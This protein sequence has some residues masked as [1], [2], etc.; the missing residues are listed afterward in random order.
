MTLTVTMT[1][2]VW[3]IGRPDDIYDPTSVLQIP[4]G[5]DGDAA[6]GPRLHDDSNVNENNMSS[7]SGSDFDESGDPLGYH[8]CSDCI[9]C[10][11]CESC[12]YVLR[13]R[14]TIYSP[15]PSLGHSC[16]LYRFG[17][18]QCTA[19]WVTGICDVCNDTL[20]DYRP[21]HEFSDWSG[22]SEHPSVV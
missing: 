21:G 16:V 5:G 18:H 2:T 20:R 7:G 12:G 22:R 8:F 6:A 13:M 4:R 15:A 17:R 9:Q 11:R 10:G 19:C 3:Y 14:R 1:T